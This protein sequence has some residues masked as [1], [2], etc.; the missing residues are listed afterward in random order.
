[1]IKFLKK[2]TILIL[3]I[4]FVFGSI[5]V[6]HFSLI[7]AILMVMAA[8][9]LALIEC[10]IQLNKGK[11]KQRNICFPAK[12][13]INDPHMDFTPVGVGYENEYFDEEFTEEDK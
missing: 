7:G 2:W 10:K 4:L 12:H 8:C 5:P 11:R 9:V 6:S 1:M 13:N 3:A